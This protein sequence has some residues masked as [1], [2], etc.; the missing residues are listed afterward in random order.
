MT[1]VQPHKGHPVVEL[2]T[3]IMAV[4]VV[5]QVTLSQLVA[6]E[7][8]LEQLVVTSTMESLEPVVRVGTMFIELVVM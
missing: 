6:E 8:V 1:P 3:E 2:V 7:A 4:A 5:D